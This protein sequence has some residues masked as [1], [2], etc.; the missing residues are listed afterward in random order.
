MKQRKMNLA[1]FVV[2]GPVSGHH[3]GWRYPTADRNL[4]ALEY[5]RNIGRILEDGRF[6]LVLRDPGEPDI[7]IQLDM[8]VRVA[9]GQPPR[10]FVVAGGHEEGV[11]VE[12]AGHG[13]CVLCSGQ[14]RGG[15]EMW[16]RTC[17][18]RAL[19][20]RP[21]IEDEAVQADSGGLGACS[22]QGWDG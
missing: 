20:A 18:R 9:L 17:E 6:D 2:A 19:S 10:G 8:G 7:V 5:Y 13:C 21:A 14:V 4:L 15:L 1:A 3:G 22:P 11:E 16:G 12:L